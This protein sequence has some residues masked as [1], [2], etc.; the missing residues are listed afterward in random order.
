MP[1]VLIADE[2]SPKAAEIF[3]ARGVEVDEITGL[4]KD[5][6][7]EII[8][9][10]DGLAVRSTT[11]ATKE[12][13]AAATN[14][15]VIGRAGIGVDNIDI[16]AASAKGVVV[17]NTPFGNSITTAEHAIALMFALAR[18]LPEADASTQAGK[19]EKNRFMGVELTAK[20]L[21]LIGAGNIGSIVA[22]RALGLK[23]KVIA[24]DP[25]L[26]PERAQ[27]LGIEKVSLDD[28]LARADVITLHTPLTDSTRNIL[29]A[30]ALAKTR[31]GVRIV[32]CARG[33]LID[34]V[35]LKAGL[36][37]GHI[38]GAAL[39]VFA[40]EPAKASPLFGTPGFVSTPHLGASTDE[41]Q[42]NV[43]IQVAEQMSDF[44]LSGGVTNALNVPSLSAEE[45]PRLKPYM[46]LAEQLGSLI[47]QIVDGGIA[48]VTVE[49][50]GAAAELNLKP[51]TAAVLAGL[52]RIHSDTV[53]MVNAPFLAR[54]RDIDVAE[55]RHE[56]ETDYHT[57]VRVTVR[58]DGGE[59][60][61]AGTLFGNRDPRLVEI[62][63]IKVEASLT[64]PMLFIVNDDKPGF[65]GRLGSTLG[66]AGVNIGT[67]HLGR[68][69]ARGEAVL[70]L[71]VDEVI[72]VN[73]LGAIKA[74][75]GV[76][77]VKALAFA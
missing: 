64:G 21:G 16:P 40:S 54:E 69:D 11:K 27:D 41:A 33:G 2:M 45:A 50:E 77:Q 46:A 18:Q 48:G 26:T 56:R 42:V 43:A 65:I 52:M 6:L 44:L 20:T 32:N 28:L 31:K 1:K 19:W 3:R 63:G 68:R 13:I 53:N 47:G 58:S 15:K 49:V 74:L 67:F 17:M 36:D 51:I 8:G 57:L 29:S 9:N 59:H 70:L 14:L 38:A 66:E 7:I 39:D 34:E 12:V 37:S 22:D 23:M 35:A 71:S 4:T 75:P 25:F 72:P 30:D 10:Y 55:V 73:V 76:R 61:V 60:S 24:F 62:I 5:A